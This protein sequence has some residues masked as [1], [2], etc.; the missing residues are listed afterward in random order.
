MGV[1]AIVIRLG[2]FLTAAGLL[3]QLG[4]ELLIKLADL[5]LSAFDLVFELRFFVFNLGHGFD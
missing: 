4:F 1:Q 2:I 3:R 5:E